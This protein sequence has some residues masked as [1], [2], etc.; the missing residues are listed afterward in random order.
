MPDGEVQNSHFEW[1]IDYIIDTLSRIRIKSF[2][3]N[4]NIIDLWIKL[5]K[6][7]I[8]GLHNNKVTN[9]YDSF[10]EKCIGINEKN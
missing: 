8:V 9:I 1:H 2:E 6:K 5:K 3:E 4:I 10:T 7:D